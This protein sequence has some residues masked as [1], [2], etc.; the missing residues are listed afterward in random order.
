MSESEEVYITWD[1]A[2]Y[3]QDRVDHQIEW[4]NKSSVKN[5]KRY[6]RLQ[7]LDLVVSA[8]IP[9]LSLFLGLSWASF[10]IALLGSFSTLLTGI[11]ALH[12]YR[13][14]W[15]EYRT[16]TESLK[17]EKHYFVTSTGPYKDH[18][19]A[20]DLLVARVESLIS[21]QNTSWEQRVGIDNSVSGGV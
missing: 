13:D 21:Q 6:L 18:P 5:K 12:S 1:E 20:F 9:V 3:L 17:H 19:E 15:K 11:I 10:S 7:S 14:N 16:V 4:Y 8:S 2:K